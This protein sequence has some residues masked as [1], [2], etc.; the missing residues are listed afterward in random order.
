MNTPNSQAFSY[1]LFSQLCTLKATDTCIRNLGFAYPAFLHPYRHFELG[2]TRTACTT[3]DANSVGTNLVQTGC[4]EVDHDIRS[5][6]R[7][8]IVNFIKHLLEAAGA[9]D[10]SAS[11]WKLGNDTT[12]ILLNL[13]NWVTQLMKP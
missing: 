4:G 11:A 5:D 12:S 8:R 13:E 10:G 3:A 6:V 9:C 1:H 7:G 2:R